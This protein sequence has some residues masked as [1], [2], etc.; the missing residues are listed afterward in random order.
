MLVVV[1]AVTLKTDL[2]ARIAGTTVQTL[3]EAAL[4]E[5]VTVGGVKVSYFPPEV[6]L[7]GVVIAGRADGERIVG[8]RSVR[9]LFGVQDWRPGLIR[10]TVD[11]PDVH[12]HLDADGLREFRERRV[13]KSGSPMSE[14]PWRELVVENGR[15]L[16]EGTDLRVELLDLDVGAEAGGRSDIAFGGLSVELGSIHEKAGPTRFKHVLLSPSGVVAP[17]I[18]VTFDHFA[19]DGN[20]TVIA[21]G[22]IAG[23]L[24]LRVAL[25]GFT[26]SPT[27]ARSYVD[28]LVSLDVTLGG[29]TDAPILDGNIA[30]EGVVLW[31]VD[32]ADVP[33]AVRLGEI[34][35]PVHF[36][37]HTVSSERLR[38][39]WGDGLVDVIADLDTETLALEAAVLAEG[40]H[41]GRVLRQTGG[42]ADPWVDFPADIEA[43][44]TGS[45][46]PFRLEGPF[47]INIGNLL[48]RNGAYDTDAEVMLDV[49]RA[50]LAGALTLDDSHIIL[51][52][53]DTR[54]GPGHGRAWA[55]IGF[56]PNGPLLLRA[57]LSDVDLSWLAPLGGAGLGGSAD[58]EGTLAGPFDALHA[59]A[60]LDV[61][62]AVVLDLPIADALRAHLETDLVRLDFTE[63]RGRRGV[64]DFL[65]NYSLVVGGDPMWMDTQIAIPGGRVADLTGIF[66]DLPGV[67]GVVRGN[68]LLHGPPTRLSGEVHLEL[69]VIEV[70][71]EAFDSG[72]ATV[73]MDDGI[74]TID[75]LTVR[76]GD[77]QLLARGSVGRGYAMNV[78]V[79]TDGFRLERLD[80]LAANP[81][82]VR[83]ELV[84]DVRVGGTLQDWEPRGRLV[85]QR[86]QVNGRNVP[87]S[88]LVFATEP[89]GTLAWSGALLGAAATLSGHLGIYGEQ[90]YDVHAALSNFPVHLLYPDGADG[91]ALSATLTGEVDLAG[92]IGDDP[93]PV[94]I[95][96]RLP[97]VAVSWGSHQLSNP[98]DWV[99]AVH[100]A[101]VQVPGLTLAGGRTRLGVEGWTTA[102]GRATFRAGGTAD[103]DLVRLFA[104]GV[105]AAEGTM[106]IDAEFGTEAGPAGVRATVQTQGA[107]LRTDY[108]PAIFTNLDARVTTD[109]AGYVIDRVKAEVGG[110]RVAAAGTITALDWVPTRFDL[111][112]RLDDAQIRYFDYLPTLQGSADLRFDG[113]VGDLLLSGDIVLADM[114]FRDRVDWEANILALQA[115]RL[116]ESA[117][118][119]REDYFS[120]DLAV[121]AADT[122]RLRNNLAEGMASASLRV[123]GDTQRPGMIG[124]IVVDEGG[125][126]YL[127]DRDFEVTR[128]EIRFIDPYTFDPDLDIALQTEV[129]GREQSYRV[130]YSVTGPFS[131]WN[132]TTSS[133]P[134]LSQADVN[135]L[136]LFGM[137][138]EEFEQYGGVAA[139]ALAAQATDLLAAQVA[140]APAQ[141][142]DRWNL[143]SGSSARGTPTLDSNWRVVGQKDFLGFTATG[144]LDLADYDVYLAIERQITRGLFA[145][146]Y[147]TSQE[148]GRTLDLG[149]AFGAELKYRWELD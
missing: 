39:L 30:T 126:M 109:G 105:A 55:D 9:A 125:H 40:V 56:A 23:D 47:E 32:A 2:V 31:M 57:V 149:A 72:E 12:L 19:V 108:F 87:D 20:A 137:T 48:V 136:L 78:E 18:D 68:A 100:G 128:G 50:R 73:W 21:D 104:P 1:V 144:E 89:G 81:I 103:L 74:L 70:Y 65:G 107:T 10:L 130:Y 139:A 121:T 98:E 90:P 134:Y 77:E 86:A 102:D 110:G 84:G 22:P 92:Q 6:A 94:D 129:S 146:A 4:G 95:D 62:D 26:T 145:S 38:L 142:V 53:T 97:S 119:D 46:D 11:S 106:T 76:R 67:D 42:F 29:T 115:G 118:A 88:S 63:I 37:G 3:V 60:T 15:F 122:I 27:D 8:V 59:S 69:D 36:A 45:L 7:E 96:A 91:T 141:L 114:Q 101:S 99:I 148:E 14:F 25:P 135:T 28:G 85:F 5:E 79:L 43:H 52:A 44:V 64:T 124:S 71:G 83:G 80:H 117:S 16:I 75:D 49:P 123:V 13:S 127:Q 111:S 58:V 120:L 116:T 93:T 133:D 35:G 51:D 82:D 41:L 54:V 66:V 140:S 113:P 17:S 24:S 61:R 147:S 112:A 143:V 131:D 34:V 138:R 132:T 33:F